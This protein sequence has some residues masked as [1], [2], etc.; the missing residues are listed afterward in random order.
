METKIFPL[1]ATISLLFPLPI[2]FSQTVFAKPNLEN[3]S[4]F[5][6]LKQL[7]GCRKGDKVK[8][9]NEL[10]S[11][12]KR[13]GYLNSSRNPNYG[14]QETDDDNFDEVLESAIKTY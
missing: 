14:F 12:L 5:D 6:F 2:L 10:K 9:V 13:F 4:P 11:Y 8:G 1:F 3:Q 7:E